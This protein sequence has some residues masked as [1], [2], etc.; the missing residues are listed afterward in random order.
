MAVALPGA[1]YI[2]LPNRHHCLPASS[3]TVNVSPEDSPPAWRRIGSTLPSCGSSASRSAAGRREFLLQNLRDLPQT[4][5]RFRVWPDIPASPKWCPLPR[6]FPPLRRYPAAR[7]TARG[8]SNPASCC[9][10]PLTMRFDALLPCRPPRCLSIG[11]AHGVRFP[12][13]LDQSEITT[14][15]RQRYPLMRLANRKSASRQPTR[16]GLLKA[17]LSPR[18]PTY[19]RRFRGWT[20]S[21]RS[22]SPHLSA[23]AD[24]RLRFIDRAFADCAR[25]PEG[26]RGLASGV[27]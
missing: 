17:T 10:L 19:P 26:L 7:A 1:E 27:W 25:R 5:S 3:L 15:F 13:E 20:R 6:G 22:Q 21:V 2:K 12:S 24:L 23:V 18:T 8:T 14:A 4:S 16:E 9:V 11:C